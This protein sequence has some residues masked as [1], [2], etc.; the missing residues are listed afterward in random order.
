MLFNTVQYLLFLPIV[1]LLYYLLP[2][3]ARLLWLLGVSYYFYMQWNPKY[4]LLLFSCTV[5]TYAG[6]L[7][8]EH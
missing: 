1:V 7:V 8:L 2:A 3:K 4:V 5:I 6:G